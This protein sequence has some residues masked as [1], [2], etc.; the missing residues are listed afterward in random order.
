RVVHAEVVAVDDQH[1]C[2]RREAQ[3]LTRQSIHDGSV[4]PT[5][6]LGKDDASPLTVAPRGTLPNAR[7]VE[8]TASMSACAATETIN[9]RTTP[10]VSP[11]VALTIDVVARIL[12]EVGRADDEDLEALWPG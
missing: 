7:A 6:R 9:I 1:P 12:A 2:V 4:C 8:V 10:L 3:Q 5:N 11:P